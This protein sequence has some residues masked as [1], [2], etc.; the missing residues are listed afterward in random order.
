MT[1]SH[2]R[3]GGGTLI[4]SRSRITVEAALSGSMLEVN[5]TIRSSSAASQP[6]YVIPDESAIVC[7]GNL[8]RK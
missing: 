8:S 6:G 5:T 1:L 3:S 2:E 7:S 4:Q